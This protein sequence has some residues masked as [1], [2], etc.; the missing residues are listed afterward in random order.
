MET[1]LIGIVLCLALLLVMTA[2]AAASDGN[3]IPNSGFET[4]YG[5][6]GVP[7]QYRGDRSA[8]MTGDSAD[9]RISTGHRGY[10]ISGRYLLG[11]KNERGK[12]DEENNNS[13]V[14]RGL[15]WFL[16]DG[17]DAGAGCECQPAGQ[18]GVRRRRSGAGWVAD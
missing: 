1:G 10:T 18:S 2:T 6:N 7:D 13:R 3:F 9:D 12:L 17:R 11:K 5:S 15:D 14:V 8:R 16:G 4:N